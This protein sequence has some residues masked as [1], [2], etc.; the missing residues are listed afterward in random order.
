M[1]VDDD[2]FCETIAMELQHISTL[3]PPTT[4]QS[5]SELKTRVSEYVDAFVNRSK[6]V[7]GPK[8]KQ[9]TNK[10]PSYD[11][12]TATSIIKRTEH[13]LELDTNKIIN[14]FHDEVS[15]TTNANDPMNNGI[16]KTQYFNKRCRETMFDLIIVIAIALQEI[17][18]IIC[19]AH[20][21]PNST[22]GLQ[23]IICLS[24]IQPI[25]HTEKKEGVQTQQLLLDMKKSIKNQI[26]VAYGIILNGIPLSFSVHD[27][28]RALEDLQQT[29]SQGT[30]DLEKL[31]HRIRQNSDIDGFIHDFN[32]ILHHVFY[33]YYALYFRYK[34][35][36]KKH[37]K[38]EV[39]R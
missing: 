5:K 10:L 1:A 12:E 11:K 18:G 27:Q 23:N 24:K 29:H 35:N 20:D 36:T 13:R 25:E 21:L 37:E 16:A 30:E 8:V 6:A 28:N 38:S 31:G 32:L 15:R 22:L 19:G 4:N 26:D 34:P 33:E 9:Y 2:A 14:D 17:N 39:Q 3:P 7:L